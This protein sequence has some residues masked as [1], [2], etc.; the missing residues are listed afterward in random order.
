MSAKRIRGGSANAHAPTST[1][2]SK[3]AARV[4]LLVVIAMLAAQVPGQTAAPTTDS[5]KFFKNYFI[6]GGYR[7]AGVG[8]A[9]QGVNGLATGT[10]N[11][12]GV[13][14]GAEI[15]AAFLY[16]QVVS[17][18]GGDAAGAGATFNGAPLSIPS[19]TFA[20][21]GDPN[22]S[23]PCWTGGPDSGGGA[24]RTYSLRYDVLRML[25]RG[26]DGRA[27][28]NGTHTVQLPDVANSTPAALG[29]SLVVFYRDPNPAAKLSAFVI[30]DGGWAMDGAT[31]GM[32]Q[33]IRGFYD[34][35][36]VPG[37]MTHIVG[38]G[39]L[40][41][42]DRLKVNGAL[43][44]PNGGINEFRGSAGPAW[45]NVT[46][47]VPNLNG[48]DSFTT[49]VDDI[50]VDVGD[51][52]TWSA[53][54]YATEVNDD[55]GDGYLNRWESAPWSGTLVDPNGV[56]LPNLVAMGTAGNPV[57]PLHKD[58]FVEVGF[59]RTYAATSNAGAAGV[60]YGGELK[61]HHT[62]R[63]SVVSLTKVYQ[64]FKTA[65]VTN[66]D[67]TTGI[68]VHID[69]GNEY[70]GVQGLIP[71]PLARGGESLDEMST[72][73]QADPGDPP[74]V[75]QFSQFPGTMGWKTGFRVIRD[76]LKSIPADPTL[77]DAPGNDGPGE[78]CERVFDRNR[79]QIFR[80]FF[81]PHLLGVPKA[82]CLDLT[83]TPQ[84]NERYG[85]PDK[86]CQ[87]TNPL[88]HVPNTYTGIADFGGGDG[89]VSMGGFPNAAGQPIGTDDQ[90]AS[91]FM[92]EI[93]HTLMLAHGG[94]KGNAN[95]N[96]NYLSIM[97]YMFQLRLLINGA[98][99]KNI[100]YSAQ[101]LGPL[102][103]FAL[104]ETN[105]LGAVPYRT[106]WYV[107]YGGVGTK[108]TRHCDGSE[109]ANGAELIR[110]DGTSV[111]GGIDWDGD[112][113]I[114]NGTVAVDINFNGVEE[115]GAAPQKGFNDWSNVR[116]NQV[117]ARR[118]IGV[119]FYTD[120]DPETPGVEVHIGPASLGMQ[121]TDFGDWDFGDWDFGDW[122]FG[123]WDFGDWDFGDPSA[124]NYGD[125]NLGDI[126]RNSGD[127]DFGDWDFGDWDFGD[128]D[129]GDWDFGDWDFG[130]WDF[131]AGAGDAGRGIDGKGD[132]GRPVNGGPV[133]EITR[134]LA[135]AAG[136]FTAPTNNIPCVGEG[137]G[138]PRCDI[139]VPGTGL[140]VL[141]RWSTPDTPPSA[142]VVYRRLSTE[143]QFTAV[144]APVP[145]TTL[146][147][148]DNTIA[149]DKTY[150]YYV[151]ARYVDSG[152]VSERPSNAVS[153]KTI[154]ASYVPVAVNN[155]PPTGAPSTGSTFQIDWRYRVNS[156]VINSA[157]A[158]P[159]VRIR[160][161]SNGIA[162]VLN[163]DTAGV[164]FQLP[165]AA[166]GWTWSFN[167]RL[168]YPTG[169]NAGQNLPPA[170]DYEI[171]ID[172]PKAVSLVTSK[173]SV[174]N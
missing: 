66:P 129:F 112:G 96:S 91:T 71:A 33:T 11:M 8:L 76:A 109:I 67:L 1:R 39:R 113:S 171:I 126:G 17:A 153:I 69:I 172:S 32:F 48:A 117:G 53:I 134:E 12:A 119:F 169:P 142:Y 49:V 10:I 31:H 4:A 50:G 103:E 173:F 88:F 90:L 28:A 84:S 60:N 106:A 158:D 70:P 92:H 21:V 107:P 148:V 102:D 2:Y 61:P 125:L 130:D 40:N 38:S 99:G 27:R 87:E 95:C 46:V 54:I 6:T 64:A 139:T 114:E 9:G 157:D 131:G 56:P 19:G 116:L 146:S 123:D 58:L 47:T 43:T 135:V 86:T 124:V 168:I 82:H 23:T 25:P 164:G 97:N 37:V 98:G 83:G 22:G 150:F 159:I 5:L 154:P 41:R 51:C 93:G 145:P 133:S 141:V 75:C 163:T 20:A 24:N 62:H 101:T 143:T 120:E 16:A 35:A 13:P 74:G 44:G 118:N 29:A 155:L 18:S 174:I 108:A 89:A 166:N 105:G 52:L 111:S 65:P 121:K 45:D 26:A 78:P 115:T 110:V 136:L 160:S 63:P 128:W 161:S 137:F 170:D 138:A 149:F 34:P 59:M 14:N 72:V 104:A 81:F 162:F 3:V 127:W 7:V 167:V 85:L 15:L 36:A 100:N 140:R 165:T 79:F 68:N 94:F 144:G 77:C 156:V 122:D 42:S 152:Q 147:I 55:D 73:C 132:F 30:Y 80:Y 57:G 151:A